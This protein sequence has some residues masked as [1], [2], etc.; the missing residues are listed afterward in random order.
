MSPSHT[1]LV[2]LAAG[3]GSRMGRASSNRPKAMLEVNGRTLIDHQLEATRRAGLRP[4]NVLVVAGHAADRL[5]A[6]VGRRAQIVYNPLYDFANNIVSLWA[7]TPYVPATMVIMN[8][9]VIF[10]GDALTRVLDSPRQNLLAIRR[11]GPITAEDMK[12]VV[13]TR[14]RI[15]RIG[16]DI[17]I[18]SAA[19]EYVGLAKFSPRGV[20]RLRAAL[21]RKISSGGASGWYESAIG[22]TFDS[23]AVHPLWL[24]GLRV[25]EIDTP[26]DLRGARDM[27]RARAS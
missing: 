6:H 14:G 25:T 23:I 15:T 26:A 10:D 22:H 18:A 19:G 12:V 8:S 4:S 3:R 13:G 20:S 21:E 7:A 2:I 5:R 27:F 11:E 17:P 9:D 16:K 24:D 1:T